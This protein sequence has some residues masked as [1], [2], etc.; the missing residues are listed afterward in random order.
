[1]WQS[2]QNRELCSGVL[3]K[4]VPVF[5]GL[6]DIQ[7]QIGL[8]RFS[9]VLTQACDLDSH[10]KAKRKRVESQAGTRWNRQAISQVLF[11]PLFEESEFKAGNHLRSGFGLELVPIESDVWSRIQKGVDFRYHFLRGESNL[12]DFVVDFKHFF[13]L[14][15][16]V[17]DT[18]SVANASGLKLEHLHYTSLAD[19]FAHYVQRVAIE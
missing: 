8:L 18:F 14:P 7:R 5:A 2:S 6:V 13:T 9:L 12:P 17:A 3:L 10:L 16:D 11:L 19:R 1:M 15:F 4:D